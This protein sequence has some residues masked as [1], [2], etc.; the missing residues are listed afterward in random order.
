[1]LR[2]G[3]YI[4]KVRQKNRLFR[5]KDS[6]FAARNLKLSLCLVKRVYTDNLAHIIPWYA[7]CIMVSTKMI[8]IT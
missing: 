6:K 1:M 3:V 7:P 8:I 2:G 4:D 5:Q